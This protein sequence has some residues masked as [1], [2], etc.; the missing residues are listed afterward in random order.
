M[1]DVF[2]TPQEPQQ[3]RCFAMAM[4][5]GDTFEFVVRVVKP[6]A[7]A[8]AAAAC[9]CLEWSRYSGDAVAF[10]AFFDLLQQRYLAPHLRRPPAPRTH[11]SAPLFIPPPLTPTLRRHDADPLLAM[12]CSLHPPL[13]ADALRACVQF[14]HDAAN[15]AV[16]LRDGLLVRLQRATFTHWAAVAL[17]A[18]IV[19][20]MAR[21]AALRRDDVHDLHAIL[22]ALPAE[23]NGLVAGLHGRA[24]RAV[25]AAAAADAVA[26]DSKEVHPQKQQHDVQEHGGS[27]LALCGGA[28]GGTH[29]CRVR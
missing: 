17:A 15:A 26:K 27:G 18:V 29:I 13:Q 12:V 2:V 7:G 21:C 6:A 3:L 11:M 24:A 23:V 16:L 19:Q 20:R 1:P 9:L 14:S 8:G 5:A 10:V 25:D 4:P 22:A 28:A